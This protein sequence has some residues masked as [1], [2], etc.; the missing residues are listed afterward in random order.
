MLAAKL[1]LKWPLYLAAD[2]GVPTPSTPATAVM[3]AHCDG[4]CRRT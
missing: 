3:A 4:Y 2:F 1:G